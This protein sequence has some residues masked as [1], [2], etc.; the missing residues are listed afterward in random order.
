[1]IELEMIPASFPYSEKDHQRYGDRIPVVIRRSEIQNPSI[2]HDP[3]PSQVERIRQSLLE[4]FSDVFDSSTSFKAME[5]PP[6]EIH[7]K[8]MDG[9]QPY[10]CT[11]VRSIPHAYCEP[12]KSEM[13]YMEDMGIVENAEDE[14]SDWVAPFLVVGKPGGG[15]RLVVD[16]Q[17]LN[18]HIRR[19]VHP[20]PS[21]K[22]IMSSIP[23]GS[24]FF[25]VMDAT[26][27]FW[28]IP[29]SEEAKKLTTFLSPWGRKRFCR[30]PM[31][32]NC[33]GDEYCARGDLALQGVDN[34]KKVV[35]DILVHGATFEQM[36]RS[37]RSVLMRCREHKITLS[38]KKF[39]FG[40]REVPYVGFII[41]EDRIRPD[42]AKL[43]A[44]RDFPQPANVTDLRAF[45]G[46][47]NQL[48][49]FSPN[50][51]KAVMPLRVHWYATRY[52]SLSF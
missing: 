11:T 3:S 51:A 7:L 39:I 26:K 35:D 36:Y 4:Q 38:S 34:V 12:A 41:G 15:V 31:G 47:L 45:F 23:A 43:A 18:K 5:G 42:P 30:A 10:M 9:V 40:K 37:F 8:N 46:L 14:P 22:D 52:A 24:K 16:N 19:P 25:S 48:D 17:H 29:I 44:I 28:Q 33:S 20:F 50:V 32:L 21:T 13:Q 1:M 6:M 27:G 2:S 49:S